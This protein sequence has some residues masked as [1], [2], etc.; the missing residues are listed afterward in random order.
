MRVGDPV[1][2]RRAGKVISRSRNLRG[3]LRRFGTHPVKSISISR[4]AASGEG[5]LLV[6]FDD[7]AECGTM[8]ASF[9]VCRDWI[10]TRRNLA[11]VPVE[12][13]PA[14]EPAPYR[15]QFRAFPPDDGGDVD[16]IAFF[17]DSR[18]ECNSGMVMSYMHVGQHSEASTRFAVSL[19]LATPEEYAPL[20]AELRAIYD[21]ADCQ[22]VVAP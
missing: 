3:L 13:V 4:V 8:F 10:A 2:I 16:V 21:G 14:D 1:E 18:G 6:T 7:G 19:R 15:V 9:D 20:L 12:I 5:F 11:G 22:L 17:L